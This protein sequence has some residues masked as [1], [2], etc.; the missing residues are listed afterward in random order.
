MG[1]PAAIQDLLLRTSILERLSGPLCDASEGPTAG[2][3]STSSSGAASCSSRSTTSGAATATTPSSPR[4]SAPA[5][6][7]A[8]GR[9]RRAFTP[10]P[11]RGTRRTATT[12]R[13]CAHAAPPDDLET[14]SRIV[15][16]APSAASTPATRAR[17]GAGWT[18]CRM[19]PSEP[20]RSSAPRTPG[21]SSLPG[22][23]A[24]LPH[25]ARR[26]RARA[27]D[28]AAGDATRRRTHRAHA[29]RAGPLAPR[30]PAGRRRDGRGGG[31]ASRRRPVPAGLP[32]DAEATLSGDATILLARALAGCRG[33]RRR[34]TEAYEASLPDLRA[35][36][37]S[38]PSA[39]RSP[40]CAFLAIE[41]G[42]PGPR[43]A[44]LRGGDRAGTARDG[45]ADEGAVWVSLAR[46]RAASGRSSWRSQRRSRALELA[47][48][49]GDAQVARS[50]RS[51]STD[52][53]HAP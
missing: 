42:D 5:C 10:A 13:R 17:C 43:R 53:R 38:A 51:R 4:S 20:T 12:T 26:C 48:R 1:L 2:S 47:S 41:R 24:G 11:R 7:A 31:T 16:D 25:A 9:D 33:R 35:G 27:R 45:G 40:T 36:G 44:D 3:D 21:A 49:A 50:A 32:P 46:A 39:V 8:A 30:R 6:D 52:S 34:R 23:T 29:A 19:P 22:E 18:P 37:P 15:A 14:A 28:R